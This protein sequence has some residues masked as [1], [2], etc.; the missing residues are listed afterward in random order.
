MGELLLLLRWNSTLSRL[1][2]AL[3]SDDPFLHWSPQDL[4]ALKSVPLSRRARAREETWDCSGWSDQ[5]GL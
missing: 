2:P 3:T 1:L 5:A 4:V